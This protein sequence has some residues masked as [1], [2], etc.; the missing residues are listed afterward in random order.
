MTVA[1]SGPTGRLAPPM[2]A[3]SGPTHDLMHGLTHGFTTGLTTGPVS[4]PR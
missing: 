3:T 2:R 1:P 4:C